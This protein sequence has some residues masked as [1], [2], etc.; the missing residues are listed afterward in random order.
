MDNNRHKNK[1]INHFEHSELV[2][3]GVKMILRDVPGRSALDNRLDLRLLVEIVDVLLAVDQHQL[4][5]GD[6]VV[7]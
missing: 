7:Q 5:G 4:L 6:E 2:H 3:N 1:S